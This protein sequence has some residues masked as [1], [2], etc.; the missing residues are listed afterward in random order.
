MWCRY[1]RRLRRAAD[2]LVPGQNVKANLRL[3]VQNHQE[4]TWV[5]LMK[6]RLVRPPMPWPSLHAMSDQDLAAVFRYL[7]FLGPAG[8][9]MPAFVPP[10]EEPKTPY[11]LMVPQMPGK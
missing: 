6:A 10:N 8:E 11:L 2:S 3:S 4:Q 9:V 7:K 1:C 5:K